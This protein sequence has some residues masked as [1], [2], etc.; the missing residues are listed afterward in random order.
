MPVKDLHNGKEFHPGTK[1][2]LDIFE[3]YLT[4]WLPT[5]LFSN[6]KV[7][8]CDFFS[9]P[10]EDIHR[11]P[12]S[13]LRIFNVLQKFK[14]DILE[15]A[16]NIDVI[17]NE[18]KKSKYETLQRNVQKQMD[19]LED[20]FR[21]FINVKFYNEDFQVLFSQLESK[22]INGPNLFF[23][24]QNG[25]KQITVDFI[26]KLED[27]NKTDYLFFLSS[28]Y[29][30]RFPFDH[31]FPDL[32]IRQ[33]DIDSKEIHRKVVEKLRNLLPEDS[34]TKLY[35]FSIKKD[36]NIY[37]LVFGATHLLAVEKFLKVAWNENKINGEANFDIDQDLDTQLDIFSGQPPKATKLQRFEAELKA[38]TE[39]R[40]QFTN[41]DVFH[42]TLD[43]GFTPQ[44]AKQILIKLKKDKYLKHFSHAKIGYKQIYIDNEI[45]TFEYIK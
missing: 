23:F 7:T 30:K 27:F 1:T 18:Q 14:K 41:M 44:H 3:N 2:K 32:N 10:G 40:K 33:A 21:R 16:V 25:V 38:F 12:G 29:F 8:I 15:K 37:G 9:G 20:N 24:D 43:K 45:I 6:S 26:R 5:F 13:P 4:E 42:Y 39:Q 28:S 19:V 31:L 34:K 35:H 11:N 36:R 22:L 17:L